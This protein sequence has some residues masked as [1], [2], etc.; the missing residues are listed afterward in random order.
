MTTMTMMTMIRGGIRVAAVVAARRHQDSQRQRLN[1]RGD[2][3]ERQRQRQSRD[4][5]VQHRVVVVT[6]VAITRRD[7]TVVRDQAVGQAAAAGIHRQDHHHQQHH[8]QD[9]HHQQHH[10][11]GDH[12]L[13]APVPVAVEAALVK[14]PSSPVSHQ[15]QQYNNHRQHRHHRQQLQQQQYNKHRH[16]VHQERKVNQKDRLPRWKYSQQKSPLPTHRLRKY[17]QDQ[18]CHQNK[19][20][21]TLLPSQCKCLNQRHP[22][23][24]LWT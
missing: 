1:P 9:H 4:L 16:R 5:T 10:Q 11:D 15:P 2:L 8:H 18:E 12:H 6:T 21:L 13:Q 19:Q 20:L 17:E 3:K 24:N 14:S 23:L 22:R 7:Q